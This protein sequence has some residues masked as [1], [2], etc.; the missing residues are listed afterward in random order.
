[1][2]HSNTRVFRSILI[3]NLTRVVF[4][5]IIDEEQFEVDEGLSQNAVDA[6]GEILLG[7]VDGDD[8]GYFGHT[9]T[10]CGAAELRFEG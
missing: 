7:V 2:E 1:M 6:A 5:T 4:A 10:G 8:D 9:M 3:A